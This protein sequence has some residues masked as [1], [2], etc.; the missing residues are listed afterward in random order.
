MEAIDTR[1]FRHTPAFWT[2]RTTTNETDS[3]I[4][5]EAKRHVSDLAGNHDRQIP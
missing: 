1:V 5:N 2:P 4:V 3:F